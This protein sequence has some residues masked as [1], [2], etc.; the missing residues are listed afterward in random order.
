MLSPHSSKVPHWWIVLNKQKIMFWCI[1]R[2]WAIFTVWIPDD[3]VCIITECV[4]CFVNSVQLPKD[5]PKNYSLTIIEE[6][7]V[8]NLK[9]AVIK[10]YDYYQPSTTLTHFTATAHWHTLLLSG[11]VQQTTVNRIWRIKF[12][13][14][15]KTQQVTFFHFVF[16]LRWPSWDWIHLPISCR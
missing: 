11:A 16:S 3:D 8:E 14:V 13:C 9:P 4:F 7:R 15:V 12:K 6:L 10:I 5:M 2:R 1:Y